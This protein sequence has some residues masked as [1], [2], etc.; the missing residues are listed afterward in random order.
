MTTFNNPEPKVSALPTTTTLPTTPSPD[1]SEAGRAIPFD[2]LRSVLIVIVVFGHA[3]I[4][5]A[6]FIDW[7]Y[8]PSDASH[9]LFDLSVAILSVIIMPPIF[10]IAGYFVVPTVQRKGWSVFWQI[11]LKRL[12]IPWL[13]CVVFVSP[14]MTYARY[15]HITSSPLAYGEYLLAYLAGFQ[16]LYIGV[17]EN[18]DDIDVHHIWWHHL[19][20]IPTL[21]TLTAFSMV[22]FK[23]QPTTFKRIAQRSASTLSL[24]PVILITIS[25]LTIY[26][27][28]SLWAPD[29]WFHN[30]VFI[31]LFKAQPTRFVL[32]VALFFAGIHWYQHQRF[33]DTSL[34]KL[35]FWHH[36]CFIASLLAYLAVMQNIGTEKHPSLTLHIAQAVT[37]VFAIWMALIWFLAIAKKYL[38]VSNV[39]SRQLSAQSFNMYLCHY[40]LAIVIHLGL[41]QLIIP[42]LL[43]GIIAFITLFIVSFGISRF[44]ITPHP[45]LTVIL[46]IAIQTVFIIFL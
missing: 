27:I 29:Y 39:I 4:P 8:I 2:N 34:L 21:L 45:R 38:G 16:N 15:Y 33:F 12:W 31:N 23:L 32:Y 40:P 26:L 18:F 6:S 13:A 24:R 42:V 9:P 35:R 3:I 22:Y 19:W 43:K 1:T 14:L 25:S 30:V 5:Y 7:W 36:G 11:R 41:N 44:L 46:L 17:L 20:F 10:F 28:V 37:V